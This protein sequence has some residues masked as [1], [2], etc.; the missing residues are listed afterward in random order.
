MIALAGRVGI[1]LPLTRLDE[2]SRSTPTLLNVKPTGRYLLEDFHYAGGT[3]ALC[4]ETTSLLHLGARTVTGQTLEEMFIN[5]RINNA[6]VIHSIERPIHSDGGLAVLTG[7]L[8]LNG[9]VIK[10]SAASPHLLKNR[11]RAVVFEHHEDLLARIDSPDLDV[12]AEDILVMKGAGPL[13][14]PGMPEWEQ[15]PIRAKL[16]KNGVCDMVRISDARISGTAFGTV[17]VNVAPESAV[18]GP[19]A[20]VQN[21]DEIQL[22]VEFR[23]LDLL[24]EPPEIQR[25][26]RNQPAARKLPERGFAR[27]YA[28]QIMQADRGCDFDF[29]VGRR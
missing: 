25:R 7:S 22:H 26:L 21:G 18:G 14:G 23:R 27:L 1:S 16:L 3:A 24:V 4:R 5:A 19:L 9:A 10:R 11:G 29:L 8:A 17:V 15:L 2:L 13:G 6:D 20:V 28:E 12:H